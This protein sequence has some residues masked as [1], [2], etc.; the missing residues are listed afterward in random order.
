MRG[1][2]STYISQ[3]YAP[4]IN[5]KTRSANLSLDTN[6]ELRTTLVKKYSNEEKPSDGEVY[7]KVRQYKREGNICFKRR[8]KACFS[9]HG[10]K[11]FRQLFDYKD[12]ELTAA[13]DDL[14]DIPGLWDGMKIST[15]HKI[16]GMKCDEVG[17]L[18]VC[19]GTCSPL[20]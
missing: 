12:K 14:L 7:R 3:V 18:S 6:S 2:Q 9:D 19:P 15:L 8:W 1:R 17:L 5:A 4:F 20:E 16:I 13:F 10:R 11:G